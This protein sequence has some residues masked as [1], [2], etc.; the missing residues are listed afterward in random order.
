[1]DQATV[2]RVLRMREAGSGF[3]NSGRPAAGVR[4]LRAALKILGWPGDGSPSW[5]V[6]RVLISLGFAEAEQGDT[7]TGLRLLAEAEGMI[8]PEHRGILLQNRG[9]VLQRAG[10]PDEALPLFDAA[11]PLLEA[12]RDD[13]TLA[14]ALLNRA[15][16]SLGTGRVRPARSDLR[17]CREIAEANQYHLII[18]KVDHD[19]GYCHLLCGDIP[20]ALRSLD[21]AADRYREHGR[22]YL[23][24]VVMDK[25]RTLLA[26]GLAGEAERELDAAFELF[27][28]DRFSVDYAWAELTRAQAAL[29]VGDL[30]AALLWS[31]RAARRFRRHGDAAWTALAE[32]TSLRAS[33]A[34]SKRPAAI[35]AR[36]G[37]LADQLHRLG[38]RYDGD[39]A[40][41]LS[42]RALIAGG[43]LETARTAVS[44]I[45]RPGAGSPLETRL[46]RRLVHAELHG[47]S[48]RRSAALASL[49]SGL[50][51]LDRHRMR[52]GS[53]ELRAGASLLGA[54]LARTGLSLA[55]QRGSA[56][57]VFDWSE[58]CRAQAFRARPVRPPADEET[59]LMVAELRQLHRVRQHGR[60]AQLERR[61]RE[62]GWQ[63]ESQAESA[64][65]VS[66]SEVHSQ[67]PGTMVCF[68]SHSDRL[69]ALVL[70]DGSASV[71]ELGDVRE[72]TEIVRRLISDLD[73]LASWNL[74]R[75]VRATI[76]KSA[77]WHLR[78]LQNR[79]LS[80]FRS[81]LSPHVVIV[82][83]TGLSAIPW[84]LLP[85]LQGRAVSV[86][87]SASV[88]SAALRS[89]RMGEREL[90]VAGPSLLR[91][92]A[93]VDS[94][95]RIYPHGRTLTG[96]SATVDATL[97]ALDGAG[98]AH[99]AAHGHHEP[100]N[101]LFSRLD[102][103]DGPLF[104]YDLQDLSHAP[105]HVVLS[106]CD[107]GR[108]QVRAGD[109]ILG[110]TAAMLYVGT[111][112][113]VSSVAR[114]PD[115]VV[116]PVMQAYHREIV[117]GTSPAQ[118]LALA[119][120]QS[121]VPLV[122]FGAG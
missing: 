15:T 47:A 5:L 31:R 19:L 108:A 3:T 50:T 90:L 84:G 118:A 12:A 111:S 94:L 22:D 34:C 96:A 114:V 87:P 46:L 71:T 18:A 100:D 28:H 10:R 112:T 68:V 13:F 102:L 120:G 69:F 64:Q 65:L 27:H 83:S 88:W 58:R 66:L 56:R 73:A 63:N 23:P 117:A 86:A 35:A 16:V 101:V 9:V 36:A 97:A 81:L 75:H 32:V 98:I 51:A 59:R 76:R 70:H 48:G 57:L 78:E 39:T 45:A 25:A 95:A 116:V 74:P 82:P 29:A 26:A 113:V 60:V 121:L 17:R 20:L 55:L 14:T 8:A 67:L 21:A 107:V 91:A 11:V 79:L 53:V 115:D 62:R 80:P 104:A 2:D 44:S 54:D 109:E 43:Q 106:A 105:R 110:L 41:L 89:Q 61:L 52:F 103:A 38:L 49:R 7:E 99:L 93:E 119:A 37:A 77:E 85:L 92:D 6:G 40:E 72:V 122:C 33:L 30:Q 1:M 4:K 42:V 24:V